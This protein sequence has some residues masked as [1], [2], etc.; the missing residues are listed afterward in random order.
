MPTRGLSSIYMKIKALCILLFLYFC[1]IGFAE[2]STV[3]QINVDGPIH[4]ITAEYV[5]HAIDYAIKQNADALIFQIQTPGGVMES[6]RS[7]I[8]RMINSPVPIIVYVAPSGSRATSAG[9]Y[10]TIA[11]D[12][13]VMAPGTH[14]GS[15]HPVFGQD[16]ADTENSKTMMKKATEDSVAYIKTLAAPRGRNVEQ[17]EKAVR[18]SIS[19][20]ETEALKL[21]LIDF[22]A[23]DVPDLLKKANGFSIHKFDGST[24]QLALQNVKMIPFEM[25]R[26]QKFLAL[27]TDPN[28]TLFLVS[29]GM[30]GL[31]IEL[32]NPGLIL[33][34]IVGVIFLSLF[35]LSVQVIPIN[36]TG[37][38]LIIFAA[39]LF[40][41]E[42]KVHSY[43]LLTAGGIVSLILG[44]TMLIDAPIPEMRITFKAILLMAV[45]VTATMALLVTMVIRLHRK[46]PLTGL[47]GLLQ[48]IGTAQ[49]DIDPE[50]QIFVHGEIWKAVSPKRISKGDKV[51]ILSAD[52][53]TLHV[54]LY[55]EEP[56]R[57]V[58]KQ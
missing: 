32:Y 41:I 28:I 18:D 8:S 45:L 40:V 19:F 30:M 36:Y 26:R 1:G 35:F 43:G 29:L 58:G 7:I 15:A 42:L 12:L 31:L 34:G 50:G 57:I 53:L 13:A 37:L 56:Y 6:M 33:P 44:A 39:I 21:K 11:A 20:T 17:A 10:I 24:K 55:Q 14:L 52:G 27:I 38:L 47:Q 16:T 49:T 46:K 2:S 48:E 51:R 22:V 5:S 23:K 54:E 25:T 4:A 9:F 3:I